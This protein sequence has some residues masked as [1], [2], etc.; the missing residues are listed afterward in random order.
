MG[1]ITR[2]LQALEKRMGEMHGENRAGL[3]EIKQTVGR[4]AELQH[5]QNG[6]VARVQT[7]TAV[8]ETR[9]KTCEDQQ[10]TTD[11]ELD[12]IQTA[13]LTAATGAATQAIQDTAPSAKRNSAI[14]AAVAGGTIGGAFVLEKV[15]PVI[16]KLFGG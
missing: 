9:M 11:E 1:E 5:V 16:V 14:A 12:R 3:A 10:R 8:L 13:A 6:N 4:L 7:Q 15:I 2:W